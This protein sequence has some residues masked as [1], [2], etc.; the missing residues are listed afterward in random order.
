MG[1]CRLYRTGVNHHAATAGEIQ[2]VQQTMRYAEESARESPS[3]NCPKAVVHHGV[4]V[5]DQSVQRMTGSVGASVRV[6][7]CQ[8]Y[9][10]AAGHHAVSAPTRSPVIVSWRARFAETQPRA[11]RLERGVF[12]QPVAAMSSRPAV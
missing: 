7:R 6:A 3:P 1:K 12:D 8:S 4:S 11:A 5:M 10:M 2:Y 9:L